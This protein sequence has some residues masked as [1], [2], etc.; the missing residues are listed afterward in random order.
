M[1]KSISKQLFVCAAALGLAALGARLSFY[2]I[3]EDEKGLLP[4]S[5]GF[6]LIFWGLFAAA[7]VFAAGMTR[8]QWK[9]PAEPGVGRLP[10]AASVLMAVGIVLTVPGLRGRDGLFSLAASLGI[11]GGGCLLGSG[12]MQSRGKK[13]YFLLQTAVCLFFAF[14]SIGCYRTWSGTPQLQTYLFELGACLLLMLYAYHQA[15]ACL[16]MGSRG[17]Q[18]FFGCLAGFFCLAALPH[19][20]MPML[21]LCGGGWVL[22]GLWALPEKEESL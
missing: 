9:A 22:A 20:Q 2:G 14:L 19:S 18:M 1:R 8:R 15:A 12:W 13:P 17:A 5:T 6:T 3:G 16:D 7:A 11:L 4:Q 10:A 21:Y